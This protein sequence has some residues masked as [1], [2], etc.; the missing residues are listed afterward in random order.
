M[1]RYFLGHTAEILW[2]L[3]LPIQEVPQR[4]LYFF[5]A[6]NVCPAVLS[7]FALAVGRCWFLLS[8]R[9][10][11]VVPEFRQ[12]RSCIAYSACP[13]WGG[14]GVLSPFRWKAEVPDC[15]RTCTVAGGRPGRP[16]R[17]SPCAVSP[18]FLP[19]ATSCCPPP[20]RPKRSYASKF[21]QEATRSTSN[22]NIFLPFPSSCSV[23]S[24]SRKQTIPTRHT[25]CPFVQR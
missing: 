6:L 18:P 10:G 22:V 20:F 13:D 11:P 23:S 9:L 7:P 12:S 16:D 25:S 2:L 1:Y 14:G 4:F 15:G 3:P 8:S 5:C 24:F 17:L 19:P 21:W